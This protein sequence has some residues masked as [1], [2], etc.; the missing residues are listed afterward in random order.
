MTEEAL[1]NHERPREGLRDRIL[2][3]RSQPLLAAVDDDGLLLLA[4]H[5][6]SARYRAGEIVAREGEASQGIF[7]VL[8]GSLVVSYQGKNVVTLNVGSAFGTI[9][10]LAGQPSG[11]AIAGEG[12]RLLE[13]PVAAFE[14]A[15]DENHSLL[16]S[17]L[18]IT[19][20]DVLK[21]RGNLPVDPHVPRQI[22]EGPYYCE[23]KSMVERLLDLRTGGF[24]AP[25]GKHVDIGRNF[26][27]G[28][29][30]VWGPRRRVYS[31]R[32]ETDVIAYRIA[33]ESFLTLL[34]SHVEVGL[35]VLRGFAQV[36]LAERSGR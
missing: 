23:T 2:A 17:A 14:N 26:S 27:I 11:L 25:D 19:G 15:L 7:V 1:S 33:F 28:V 6:R 12:T 5:A 29:L 10:L 31:A 8:E 30:D 24:T 9:A 20:S 22:D 4:E 21:L 36:L 18:A 34:E 3:L 16:R 32:A 13:I 35:E